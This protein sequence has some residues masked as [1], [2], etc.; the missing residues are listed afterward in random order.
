MNMTTINKLELSINKFK[1]SR[2]YKVIRVSL[3]TYGYIMDHRTL[4]L[5][6]M[7]SVIWSLIDQ[8]NELKKENIKLKKEIV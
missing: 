3:P 6:T 7:D 4:E 1:V 8:V 5:K 2:D